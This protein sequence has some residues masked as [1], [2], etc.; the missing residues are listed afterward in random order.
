MSIFPS[1]QWDQCEV[2]AEISCS[3]G[4]LCCGATHFGEHSLTQ[5]GGVHQGTKNCIA[6]TDEDLQLIQKAESSW[7]ANELQQIVSEKTRKVDELLRKIKEIDLE[8]SRKVDFAINCQKE[9]K[10][11]LRKVQERKMIPLV[12]NNNFCLLYTSPSPRDS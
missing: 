1:C 4:F 11:I 3:C 7:F 12:S 10:E 9:V 5:Q 2:E 6:L 8:Y